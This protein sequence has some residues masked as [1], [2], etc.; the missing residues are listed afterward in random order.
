M[1]FPAMNR[2][3]PSRE[4]PLGPGAKKD[5][6]FLQ[7]TLFLIKLKGNS[8]LKFDHNHEISRDTRECHTRFLFRSQT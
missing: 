6:L 2:R 3:R 4:T 5:G 7:A 8:I 1:M